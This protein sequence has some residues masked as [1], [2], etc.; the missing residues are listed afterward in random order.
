[1]HALTGSARFFTIAELA[2]PPASSAGFT[3][4]LHRAGMP[5]YG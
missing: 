2:K 3:K 4:L 1:V 5:R